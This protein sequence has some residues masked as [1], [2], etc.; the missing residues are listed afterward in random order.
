MNKLN[1]NSNS[2]DL[3]CRTCL[4]KIQSIDKTIHLFE[5]YLEPSKFVK[6]IDFLT[7]FTSLQIHEA[8]ELSPFICTVCYDKI[9]DI[10]SFRNTC[11]VS[12]E[13]LIGQKLDQ[14]RLTKVKTEQEEDY[15]ALETEYLEE[16]FLD[17]NDSGDTSENTDLSKKAAE[18]VRNEEEPVK[19][20]TPRENKPKKKTRQTENKIK[21][22]FVKITCEICQK[23]FLKQHTYDGHMRKH[24]GLKQ[25]ACDECGKDF[26]K[27][28]SL[29]HHME[30]HHPTEDK[31]KNE[32][33][34]GINDC[35]KIYSL[36]VRRFICLI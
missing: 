7:N 31:E 19:V 20:Q 16:E 35:G 15:D 30:T 17:Q 25:F 29:K 28:D 33:I 1:E 5:S 22:E 3:L 32:F 2:E 10:H 23:M 6:L 14:E 21:E 26:A 4:I 27:K 13:F 18:I 8:D 34:C 12:H 24:R 11:I 9:K 36:K